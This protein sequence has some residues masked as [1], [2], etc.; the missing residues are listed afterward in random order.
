MWR[1]RHERPRQPGV[2]LCLFVALASACS[3]RVEARRPAALPA[4]PD[5][6]RPAAPAPVQELVLSEEELVVRDELGRHVERLAG[7]IGERNA[8]HPWELADAADYVALEFEQAG[9]SVVRQGFEV[10]DVMAQNLEVGLAGEGQAE[11]I[12][13][14]GAHYDSPANS[15]GA[16]DN[17]SGVAMLL[18]LAGR[19]KDRKFWRSLRF[20]AFANSA[21]DA[22]A[23]DN[24]GSLVYARRAAELGEAIVGAVSLDRVGILS[25]PGVS[26]K[27]PDVQ[28]VGTPESEKLV[29]AVAL[30]L[31]RQGS[32]ATVTLLDASSEQARS[33]QWAF[34]RVGFPGAWVAGLGRSQGA[35]DS[36]GAIDLDAM[37]RLAIG[38]EETFKELCIVRARRDTGLDG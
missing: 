17:A 2:G 26:R 29:Q 20:V 15:P 31:G 25:R 24:M 30:S 38:L 33:D 32:S 13:V 16:N 1:L 18:T 14:V 34:S 28:V 4:A 9:Y 5:V 7:R 23:Q 35:A 27:R 8:A 10:G 12:V 21:G 6:A 11:Q 22:F 37:A 3:P 36:V 19:M